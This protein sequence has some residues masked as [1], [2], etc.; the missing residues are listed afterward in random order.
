MI[1]E[2]CKVVFRKDSKFIGQQGNPDG[3][4]VGVVVNVYKGGWFKVEWLHGTWEG[5]P[6][7]ESYYK[8]YHEENLKVIP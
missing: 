1:K 7:K 3:G 6:I 5:R 4:A 8:T 2:G